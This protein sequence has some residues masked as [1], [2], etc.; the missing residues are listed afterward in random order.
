MSINMTA[1]L[2]LYSPPPRWCLINIY[3]ANEQT[4]EISVSS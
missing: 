4:E 1:Q 2:T 3:S